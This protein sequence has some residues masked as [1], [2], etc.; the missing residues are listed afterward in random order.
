MIFKCLAI[1]DSFWV[2]DEVMCPL[3]LSEKDCLRDT[4]RKEKCAL[5]EKPKRLPGDRTGNG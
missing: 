4:K 3:L 1:E 5:K 2:K